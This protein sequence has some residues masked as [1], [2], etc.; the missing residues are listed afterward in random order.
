[1]DTRLAFPGNELS[2]TNARRHTI[3]E[4]ITRT[5]RPRIAECDRVFIVG[6]TGSGKTYWAS[7]MLGSRDDV[8]V[9]DSLWRIDRSS[10]MFSRA[11]IIRSVD[12]FA[13]FCEA[14]FQRGGFIVYLDELLELV[15]ENKELFIKLCTRGRA[16]GIGMWYSTQRPRGIPR[17]GLSEAEHYVIFTLTL[18]DDRKFMYEQVGRDEIL[19]KP[20]DIYGYWY[21]DVKRDRLVYSSGLRIAKT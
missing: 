13:R 21:Y 7:H 15:E 16:Q 5:Y 10:G 20:V 12:D 1:M 3:T 19:A 4:G 14:N 2:R 9:L 18:A 11:K 6:K 17:V 8:V